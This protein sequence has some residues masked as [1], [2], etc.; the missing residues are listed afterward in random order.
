MSPDRNGHDPDEDGYLDPDDTNPDLDPIEELPPVP[1][2]D[3]IHT[4]SNGVSL[5][6]PRNGR[7]GRP[8]KRTEESR[9]RILAAV[10][11]GCTFKLAAMYGG[12]SYEHF[13]IWRREDEDFADEVDRAVG[14]A[15][16]QWMNIIERAAVDDWRAAA[17]KLQHRFPGE[18]G[19]QVTEVTG[20]GGGPIQVREIT[21]R[22][23]ETIQLNGKGEFDEGPPELMLPSGD[24][25]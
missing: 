12:M 13:N 17:W 24:D 9:K 2:G 11:L 1:P 14:I 19:R 20:P 6:Q 22:V 10:R 7:R 21:V 23:P 8:S 15:A 18:Y 4:D 16:A 3:V 5:I 25:E